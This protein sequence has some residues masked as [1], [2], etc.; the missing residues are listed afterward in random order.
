MK[1][2]NQRSAISLEAKAGNQRSAN[3]LEAKAQNQRSAISLEAKAQKH[4]AAFA[5]AGCLC[6]AKSVAKT[7]PRCCQK[8]STDAAKVLPNFRPPGAGA[9]LSSSAWRTT[10]AP[11]A[12]QKPRKGDR[13]KKCRKGA[14]NRSTCRCT[15]PRCRLRP[16]VFPRSAWGPGVLKGTSCSLN[17][18]Q[19]G[20]DQGTGSLPRQATGVRGHSLSAQKSVC[21]RRTGPRWTCRSPGVAPSCGRTQVGMAQT[22]CPPA[23]RRCALRAAARPH[24]GRTSEK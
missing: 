20:P 22:Q 15:A 7:P 12:P 3:S 4:L 18:D 16:A 19:Q 11:K 21:R 1:A 6:A 9:P 8:R 13:S 10:D 24:R 23:K 14:E 2:R 5:V 17:R